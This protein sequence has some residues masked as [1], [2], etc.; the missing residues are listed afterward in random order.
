MAN[1]QDFELLLRI[2]ADI[3]QAMQGVQGFTDEIG[4]GDAAAT[5]LGESLQEASARIQQMVQASA[6]QARAQQASNAAIKETTAQVDAVSRSYA[7]QTA[8]SAS[9]AETI[10]AEATAFNA[11]VA[12]K[13]RAMQ[14]LNAA[15]AGNLATTGGTVAAEAALD[16]AMAAG[17]ITASEQAAYIQRLAAAQATEAEATTAATVAT[18]TNTA[19]MTINGGVARELGV[20]LGELA[21]GNTARLEGSLVTLGNRTGLLAALFNPMTVLIGGLVA[22]FGA[23]ALAAEQTAS[24]NTALGKAIQGTGNFAGT[25]VSQ[26]N[27]YSQQLATTTVSE[28]EARKALEAL[29][30]SGKVGASALQS[31][32]QATVDLMALTGESADK[33]SSEVLRMFDGT[34]QSLLKANEQYHFLTTSIYDQIKA[35]E[36]QGDTQRAMDVAAEAFHQAATQRIQAEEAQIIGLA[37][38]WRDVKSAVGEYYQ[39]F[40]TGASL[41]L[42]T[43][44]DQTKLYDMLGRK[45]SAQQGDY[46]TAGSLLSKVVN[47]ESLGNGSLGGVLG[48]VIYTHLQATWTA[49]DEAKLQALQAKIQQAGDDAEKKSLATSLSTGAV[50]AAADLDRLGQSLDRNKA[51]Q[52]ELNKLDADFLKLW[53]GADP[54]NKLLQGVQAITGQDGKVSFSGGAYDQFRADIDKR[55][56]TKVPKAK[57]E[58]GALDAQQDLLKLLNDQQGKLN[59]LSQA[60]ATYNDTVQRANELATKA[61]TAHG[62]DVTAINAERDAVI[63]TAAAVRDAALDKEADK[64]RDAFEKLRASLSHTNDARLDKIQDQV[65]QLDK[66]FDQANG[67]ISQGEYDDTVGKI[68]Q[69]GQEQRTKFNGVS[70][71]VGGPFGEVSKLDD[72]QKQEDE[73]HQRNLDRLQAFYA[74]RQDLTQQYID[75]EAQEWQAHSD[76]LQQI[77]DARDLAMLQGLANSF[78]QAAN[79]MKQGFGAQSEAYRVA[80]ALSKGAAIAQATLSMYQAIAKATEI[81]F[82]QNIPVIAQ[83]TAQGLQIVGQISALGAGFAEGGYTGAGG[84]YEV[85]GVVHRGEGVLNQQDIHALGG[86]QAFMALR[87]SLRNGYADGGLVGSTNG[88]S[89]PSIGQMPSPNSAASAASVINNRMRVYVVQNEDELMSRLASHPKMEKA[90]V[91][92]AGQ[93]G[94]AIQTEWQG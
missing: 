35:L 63:A 92:Y 24:E 69:N 43:A 14:L 6:A 89:I 65:K 85:A 1:T 45:Q 57:S 27:Q 28:G 22:E 26:L 70:G 53:N 46:N 21:R 33:A 9:A 64:A 77:D 60:W 39:T 31:V 34:T 49:D 16:N 48:P 84:K 74:S 56:A 58:T 93:N 80:F 83:A 38:V 30:A 79:A 94:R 25:T 5:K 12:A 10:A 59:P 75:A 3:D 78:S 44:D 17:A 40:K 61:A 36:E 32:G 11:A 37:R 82:P 13:I 72:Q 62:A 4:T 91:A 71:V 76:R 55:Y 50:D 66:L 87:A 68:V 41:I 67:K 52:S 51:K 23:L 15:F 42:G 81:G 8:A 88:F 73:L 18:N 2:R 54:N 7:Q 47:P 29:V 86:P 90:V 19:A 20:I